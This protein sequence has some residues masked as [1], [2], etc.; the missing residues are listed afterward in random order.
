MTARPAPSAPFPVTRVFHY[1]HAPVRARVMDG[2]AV[3][4]LRDLAAATG[5]RPAPGQPTILPGIATTDEAC[6]VLAAAGLGDVAALRSWLDQAAG[7]LP[8]SPARRLQSVPHPRPA[9]HRRQAA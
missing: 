4:F 9:Q 2:R 6:Q 3:W 5:T 1:Q 8:A 7:Q